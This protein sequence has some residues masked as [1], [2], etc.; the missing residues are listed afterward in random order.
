MVREYRFEE[1]CRNDDLELYII[2]IGRDI[3]FSQASLVKGFGLG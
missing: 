2:G 3:N 1:G